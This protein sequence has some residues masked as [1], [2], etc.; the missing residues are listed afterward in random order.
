MLKIYG[1][2]DPTLMF[3]MMAERMGARVFTHDKGANIQAFVRD[4]ALVEQLKQQYGVRFLPAQVIRRARREAS[5]SLQAR[6]KKV[7]A[8]DAQQP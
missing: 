1:Q 7:S 2:S 5:N 8:S 6:Y 4:A 3:R